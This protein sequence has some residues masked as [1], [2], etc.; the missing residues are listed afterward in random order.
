MDTFLCAGSIQSIPLPS[1]VVLQEGL[2]MS[3]SRIARLVKGSLLAT[4]VLSLL[5][6]WT[7][8]VY[9]AALAPTVPH[10]ESGAVFPLRIHQ[11]IV[12]L[13]RTETYF[14][15][16]WLMALACWISLNQAR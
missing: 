9:Y 6:L 14:A 5:I 12:Y 8:S 13:T 10:P 16:G 15:N 11:S 2:L 3:G 7:A 1:G 4:G